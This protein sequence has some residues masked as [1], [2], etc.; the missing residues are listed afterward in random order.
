MLRLDGGGVLLVWRP[1]QS[2]DPITY[3]VQ[4]CTDGGFTETVQHISTEIQPA[5]N[6]IICLLDKKVSVHGDLVTWMVSKF[7]VLHWKLNYF[8]LWG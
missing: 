4:Y 2:N 8:T 3:C 6:Q 1:I 7:I 5:R